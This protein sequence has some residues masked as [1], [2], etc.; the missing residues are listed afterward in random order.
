MKQKVLDE[1]SFDTLRQ[2]V[3]DCNSWNGSLEEYEFYENDEW[4]F[5][6]FFSDAWKAVQMVCNGDY[7]SLDDY[8]QW[9]YDCL[10]SYSKDEVYDELMKNKEEIFDNWYEL[11]LDGKLDYDYFNDDFKEL[12]DEYR[13]EQEND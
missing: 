9:D 4:F 11:L 12:I 6:D 3:V 8:V 13:K 7:N 5:R 10:N 2:M 1:L